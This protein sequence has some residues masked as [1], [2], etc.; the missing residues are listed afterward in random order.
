MLKG[1]PERAWDC[2]NKSIHSQEIII[3][4]PKHLIISVSL[5]CFLGGFIP[6]FPFSLNNFI[7]ILY[8]IIFY[9]EIGRNLKNSIYLWTLSAS[10]IIFLL[11]CSFL[12]LVSSSCFLQWRAALS[13]PV[14]VCDPSGPLS[15]EPSCSP[16][17]ADSGS[18]TRSEA[19][20]SDRA[21]YSNGAGGGL[22]QQAED[23]GWGGELVFHEWFTNT[24]R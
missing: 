20:T 5:V 1:E 14:A 9:V 21:V 16:P 3:L 17:A 2:Q 6:L 7:L 12:F 23:H 22:G 19:R 11:V 13:Q 10:S 24:S 4:P 15:E 8:K 18:S